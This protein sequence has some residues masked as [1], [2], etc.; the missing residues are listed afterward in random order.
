MRAGVRMWYRSFPKRRLFT[1]L[2]RR[3]VRRREKLGSPD[4]RRRPTRAEG[5]EVARA[6]LANFPKVGPLD[7]EAE[8]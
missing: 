5:L 1:R 7:P 6:L 8:G 4:S 2:Y 3:A